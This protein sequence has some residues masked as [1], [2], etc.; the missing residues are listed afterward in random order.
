VIYLV[1]PR[2]YDRRV[3]YFTC[4]NRD[5][6]SVISN[7]TS[8]KLFKT[9]VALYNGYSSNVVQKMLICAGINFSDDLVKV[10]YHDQVGNPRNALAQFPVYS[11]QSI[12]EWNTHFLVRNWEMLAPSIAQM[13]F[14]EFH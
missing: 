11:S 7:K 13:E 5:I 8:E 4:S 12:V 1:L 3:N 2:V 9:S 14:V 10:K 6:V